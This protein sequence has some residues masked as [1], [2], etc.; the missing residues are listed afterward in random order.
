MSEENFSKYDIKSNSKAMG[1]SDD[2]QYHLFA[3]I[4][5]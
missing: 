1:G 3:Y 4:K 5:T 2:I